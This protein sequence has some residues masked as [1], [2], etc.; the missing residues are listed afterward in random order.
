MNLTSCQ[1]DIFWLIVLLLFSAIFGVLFFPGI[2]KAQAANCGGVTVCACGDTVTSNYTL[3]ADLS[4]TGT[5]LTI[6]ADSITIDGAGFTISGNDTGTG[7]YN[8]GYDYATTTNLT[9]TN[10]PSGINY[11]TGADNGAITNNNISSCSSN[12]INLSFSNTNTISG[13]T[14]YNNDQNISNQNGINL[15]SSNTNT[16]SGNTIKSNSTIIYFYIS[17]S[18]NYEWFVKLF[19]L[20]YNKT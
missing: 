14:V 1:K 20:W 8:N 7:I 6:G 9:I 5:G 10:F 4:C 11:A 15:L 2:K 16:I 18:N 19:P 3:T 13:N 12:G 17:N